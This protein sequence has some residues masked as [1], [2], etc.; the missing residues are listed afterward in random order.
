[1]KRLENDRKNSVIFELIFNAAGI[2]HKIKIRVVC[3]STHLQLY[4]VEHQMQNLLSYLFMQSDET[5]PYLWD[6]HYVLIAV[7]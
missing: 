3:I 2:N 4:F 6:F 1:M 5:H 7:L